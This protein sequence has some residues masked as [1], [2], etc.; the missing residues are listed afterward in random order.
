MWGAVSAGRLVVIIVLEN[1]TCIGT[2]PAPASED[3]KSK[4]MLSK[5]AIFRLGCTEI[6]E[7]AGIAVV[8]TVTVISAGE[9]GRAHV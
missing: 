9:I 5:P 7:A 6:I 3:G 2:S 8:P 1:W 4:I